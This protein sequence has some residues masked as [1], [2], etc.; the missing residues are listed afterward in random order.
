MKTDVE[1][2]IKPL[3]EYLKVFDQFIPVLCMRPDDYAR[4]IELEENPRDI[5]LIKEEIKRTQEKEKM[6]KFL[7][8]ETVHVSI[9]EIHL[10]ETL[11]LLEER[12]QQLSK[13]LVD[14][15]AKRAKDASSK[16]FN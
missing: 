10:K 7:I 11:N 9:F 15:I 8:P 1:E 13:N 16:L 3:N 6:L 5:E 12:Y 2:S 4:E 14:V